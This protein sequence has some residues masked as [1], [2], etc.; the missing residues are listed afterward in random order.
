MAEIK[1]AIPLD[2]N[3]LLWLE[4]IVMDRD[5]EEALKFIEKIKK[6]IDGQQKSHCKPPF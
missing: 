2:S 1:T 3:D 4:Q 5:K 6:K